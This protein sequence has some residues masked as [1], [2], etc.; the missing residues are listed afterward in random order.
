VPWECP[1]R[2]RVRIIN[3]Q[4]E[5]KI[6]VDYDYQARVNMIGADADCEDEW[7]DDGE[8]EAADGWD[9]EDDNELFAA[10]LLCQ[11]I[12]AEGGDD[13]HEEQS[14]EEGAK[15]GESAPDSS[16]NHL[17]AQPS[18]DTEPKGMTTRRLSTKLWMPTHRDSSVS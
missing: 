13:D 14:W 12:S 11:H 16:V 17:G 5:P 6:L 3:R 1:S 4:Y 7:Q 10:D 18:A 2:K 15:D 8:W 9:N